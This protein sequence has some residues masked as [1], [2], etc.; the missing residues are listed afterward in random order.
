[1]SKQAHIFYSGKVQGV[2]FR[3]TAQEL[4]REFGITGWVKNLADGRVE[5]VA[6][7]K[8]EVVQDFLNKINEYFLRYIKDKDIQWSPPTGEFKDFRV[9]F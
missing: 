1:M 4:A 6:E 2:G 7:A 3:F 5:I 8:E 9:E